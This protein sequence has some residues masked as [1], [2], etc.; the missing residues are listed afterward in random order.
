MQTRLS[1]PIPI[2]THLDQQSRLLLEETVRLLIE[3]QHDIL[4]AVI[5]FG[6]VARGEERPLADVQPSDVDVLAIFEAGERLSL[7]KRLLITETILQ[8]L[9][10]HLDAPRDIN[11]LFGTRTLAEWH[12]DFVA[13]IER[14]SIIL[15][16]KE[17]IMRQEV[18]PCAY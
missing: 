7:A 4:R 16:L 13:N 6:S 2:P 14:D 1:L 9:D 11:V 15:Y 18:L 12:A 3:R 17:D 5:L 10:R 8:A